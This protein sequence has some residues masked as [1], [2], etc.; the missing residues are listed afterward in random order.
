[1]HAR[2]LPE[3]MPVEADAGASPAGRGQ[4]CPVEEHMAQARTLPELPQFD[5]DGEQAE[6]GQVVRGRAQRM[7]TL[8]GRAAWLPHSLEEDLLSEPLPFHRA[9]TTPAASGT[10]AWSADRPEEQELDEDSDF[11]FQPRLLRRA[12]SE[13]ARP[14]KRPSLF[15]ALD[16]VDSALPFARKAARVQPPPALANLVLCAVSL[17][18]G[19]IFPVLVDLSKTAIAFG[20]H[21]E[22]V[23]QLPYTPLS[24]LRTEAAFNVGLGIVAIAV[25]RSPGGFAPLRRAE[26][27]LMM[28]PLTLVYCL[29][30]IAALC[31]IDSGG[32]PLYI[33]ISNSRLL[34]AA[35]VSQCLLG[36]R[37]SPRQ[38]LLLA[39][40]SM[41]TAAFAALSA[42]GRKRGGQAD[43][44]RGSLRA[45]AGICWAVAKAFLSGT[46]AVLTELRYKKLNLWH[47]N[48]LLKGQS[49]AVALAASAV[50]AALAPKEVPLCGSDAAATSAWCVDRRGWDRWTWAV[51]AA[52]I[53]TGWLSVAVLT[54]MSAIAK[55]VCKTATAPS[56]YLLYCGTGFGGFRFEVPAFVAVSM[57]AAGILAYTA[58]PYLD[59]LR[60]DAEKLWAM[61]YPR[62]LRRAA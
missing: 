44:A 62:L 7:R 58:E 32:G 20:P 5:A 42:G 23:G 29:G 57:I 56:L 28:L 25:R 43:A 61:H 48:T 40:I 14:A 12:V 19:C 11:D 22:E 4:A 55:F 49:L 36:R 21:G 38:W 60:R 37:Q 3:L 9:L 35:G 45:A 16:A 47:A 33:A 59:A 50:H 6:L 53:G 34:F 52:E 51:L 24:V 15:A 46:A 2:S 1:M 17:V 31:A 18:A 27:H 13:P 10:A 41:A 26:L 8:P 39:E 54:R 30:D